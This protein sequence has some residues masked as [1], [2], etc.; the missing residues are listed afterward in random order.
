MT[1]GSKSLIKLLLLIV[2][3]KIKKSPGQN[4]TEFSFGYFPYI[5]FL[6]VKIIC[7]IY[8]K[9]SKKIREI[10]F[11]NFSSKKLKKS[12]LCCFW[13]DIKEQGEVLEKCQHA[14]WTK[15][16]QI[17][18]LPKKLTGCLN[19]SVDLKENFQEKF[20]KAFERVHL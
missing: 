12:P 14:I 15:S 6:K 3:Q 16:L 1:T 13:R 8:G 7:Y 17:L 10:S 2:G 18:D 19:S 11:L 9:Y 5:Q 4:T 20:T